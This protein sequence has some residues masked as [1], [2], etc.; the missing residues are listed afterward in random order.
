M[1]NSLFDYSSLAEEMDIPAEIIQLF[2][3][4][5]CEE[6]P[7][8]KMLMEIHVLRAVKAYVKKSARKELV[9]N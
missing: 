7:N 9:E 3:K 8:D 2:E 4:E 1:E 5:A 6:F